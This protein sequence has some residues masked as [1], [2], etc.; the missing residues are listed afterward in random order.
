MGEYEMGTR[1]LLGFQV[2]SRT[3]ECG[4]V[5]H[6]KV[7]L[8][9]PHTVP[10]GAGI[11]LHGLTRISF[12]D[13]LIVHAQVCPGQRCSTVRIFSTVPR[14]SL[15][16]GAGPPVARHHHSP[17]SEGEEASQP[18]CQRKS[19]MLQRSDSGRSIMVQTTHRPSGKTPN[20]AQLCDS[21]DVFAILRS[22]PVSGLKR[23]MGNGLGVELGPG[24]SI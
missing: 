10:G 5:V 7:N 11:E 12:C 23:R 18:G 4:I 14:F 19:S 2:D 24:I 13:A 20:P 22:S 15:F 1:P 21:L 16:S 6:G 3:F 9:E 17:C 8:S